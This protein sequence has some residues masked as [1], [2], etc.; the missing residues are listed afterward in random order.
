MCGESI[1][2]SI[3]VPVY[4]VE[5]YLSD[6]IDSILNQTFKNY[7]LILVNDGSSDKSGE[8]CDKY[9]KLDC[10][11]RVLHQ[12][13]QGVSRA[14]NA[15]LGIAQGAWV[16]FVDSDD[17]INPDYIEH[18]V[19]ANP[20]FNKW[21]LAVSGATRIDRNTHFCRW[22]QEFDNRKISLISLSKDD[23]Q[24][25]DSI[26]LFGTI[27]GKLY[28]L[29]IIRSNGIQFNEQLPL[30]ED[31][32]FFFEYLKYINE[33]VSSNNVGYNYFTDGSAS[34]STSR[35]SYEKRIIAYNEIYQAYRELLNKFKLQPS[36]LKK[37]SSMVCSIY[38]DAI[39][40]C[41]VMHENKSVCL[42]VLKN[43]NKKEIRDWYSPISKQGK[44]LKT[45]ITLP[46]CIIH[47]ILKS[48]IN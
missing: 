16:T 47:A 22:K 30:N 40:S 39:K 7:E 14:R 13:N 19:N 6:C 12:D 46:N 18:L 32:L 48:I 9:A 15:A 23:Y 25:L 31:Q 29:E 34:L 36:A 8:I 24:P 28:N 35:H 42:N 20:K 37:T 11:I 44:I 5:M 38:L 26:L 43:L 1:L 21:I 17:T 41:Y 33:I 45:I 10:R 4:N 27:L 3:V 2:I